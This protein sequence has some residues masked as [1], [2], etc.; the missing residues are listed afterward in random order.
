MLIGLSLIILV[1]VSEFQMHQ[2]CI[3]IIV[4]I[5]ILELKAIQEFGFLTQILKLRKA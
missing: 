3:L 2:K 5:S 1:Q 4:R